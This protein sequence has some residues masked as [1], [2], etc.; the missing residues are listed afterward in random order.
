M[1]KILSKIKPNN[2][3]TTCHVRIPKNVDLF[4]LF[5]NIEKGWR[6]DN[7]SLVYKEV[8]I[9][10][11]KGCVKL[12]LYVCRTR[13]FRLKQCGLFPIFEHKIQVKE[14]AGFLAKLT[15][16]SKRKLV[17]EFDD[18]SNLPRHLQYLSDDSSEDCF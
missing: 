17:I 5:T 2:F 3:S 15:Y 4:R 13:I 7:A 9:S 18:L 8:E 6:L 12:Q 16:L 1:V 11:R 10:L 14:L